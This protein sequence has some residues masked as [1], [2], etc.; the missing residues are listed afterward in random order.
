VPGRE[1]RAGDDVVLPVYLADGRRSVEDD[2][3]ELSGSGFR[4]FLDAARTVELVENHR[5]PVLPGVVYTRV[6]GVSFHDDAVLLPHFAAG[7][8]IEIRPEPGNPQDR[9]AL[10]V[11]G[12]GVRVGYLPDPIAS[13]LAPSGTRVGHGV[14]LM[15]WAV[16][17]TR[18]E[19]WILGSMWVR[20]AISTEP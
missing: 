17:A 20:L 16:G 6:A 1:R 12:G 14:V 9:H 2:G 13:A 11:F 7:Q 19:I 4:P 15:E 5:T 10:A 8:S 3:R 18:H